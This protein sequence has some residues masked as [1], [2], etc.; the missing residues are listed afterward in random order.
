MKEKTLSLEMLKELK[1]RIK[2][3]NNY[4]NRCIN[5]HDNGLLYL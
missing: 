3:Y 1:T 5:C 4:L 2:R